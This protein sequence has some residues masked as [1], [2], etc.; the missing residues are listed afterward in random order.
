MARTRQYADRV[1][2]I[3]MIKLDAKGR[4]AQVVE[5][6]GKITRDHVQVNRK[7]EHHPEGC[8]YLE[9]RGKG[10]TTG[11]PGSTFARGGPATRTK[12]HPVQTREGRSLAS[13]SPQPRTLTQPLA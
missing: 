11:Q 8:Y 6:N 3:K 13:R 5:R 4:F 1:N 12:D 7:D 9:W 2:V 10:K